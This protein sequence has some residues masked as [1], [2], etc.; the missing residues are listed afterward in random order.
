MAKDIELALKELKKTVRSIAL[1]Q[2]LMDCLVVFSLFLLAFILSGVEWWWAGIPAG[3]YLVFHLITTV[4]IVNL[5][6][7]ERRVPI[8]YEQLRTAADTVDDENQVINELRQEVINKL[9][10]VRNSYF[11]RFGKLT[12]R[13]LTLIVTSFLI[14]FASAG[15][16]QLFD[17]QELWQDLTTPEKPSPYEINETALALNETEAVD[18]YG[19]ASV[20]ELGYEQLNL[21]INPV[22]SE[23]DISQVK[24]P[25]TQE[26]RSYAPPE[27]GEAQ[28]AGVTYEESAVV[29]NNLK[30]VKNYFAGIA[31]E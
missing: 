28:Q 29:K 17:A 14:I 2:S 5:A 26:F 16:V 11:I 22:Q 19:N 9:K 7:I 10:E 12:T 20:A 21:Q 25:E 3:I 24:P 15:N 13:M 18:I 27:V 30:I 6:N 1:T 23:I 8:L 31:K 4:R